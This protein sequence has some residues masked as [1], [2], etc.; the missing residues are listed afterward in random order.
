MRRLIQVGPG[1]VGRVWTD[2]VA[3]SSAWEIVAC[4][5]TNEANP[6]AAAARP[7]M[8]R[9]CCFTRLT[10]ALGAVEADALLLDVTPRQFRRQTCLQAFRRGLHV[11]CEKPPAP[12]V[13]AARALATQSVPETSGCGN[14]NNLAATR[15]M[16]RAAK[17]SRCVAAREPLA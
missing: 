15:A 3:A 17:E 6:R 2:A 14:L 13:A 5:D 12:T 1:G 11:L 10:K 9:A 7:A 16:V 4:V 8:P